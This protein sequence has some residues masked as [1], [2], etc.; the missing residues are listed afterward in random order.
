ML[1]QLD[2]N[3]AD[4]VNAT[5]GPTGVEPVMVGFYIN[6]NISIGL[7]CFAMGILLGIGGLFATM[8]NAIFLG[9]VFGHMTASPNAE[10]FFHFVTAH[11]PFE[12]TAIVLSAAA[13]MRL[14]FS[15]V[16][17]GGL[18]RRESLLLAGRRSMPTMG[19][20]MLLFFLAALLEG[21]LSP[22]PAP[23]ELKAAAF[24]VSV[25]LLLIYFVVLGYSLQRG[26]PVAA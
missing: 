4:P 23:Y 21:F 3:F 6:H 17:T 15:L 1:M 25:L 7:Q 2:Q 24:S 22:S 12:L 18:N 26:E 19:A 13:G 11:A 9:A 20:A 5:G 14:G 16:D 8:F 10:N